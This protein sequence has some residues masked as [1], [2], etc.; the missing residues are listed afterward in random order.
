MTQPEALICIERRIAA[1]KALATYQVSV[2]FL[3]FCVVVNPSFNWRCSSLLSCIREVGN[4]QVSES[5][6]AVPC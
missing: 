2:R 5:G 1:T 4:Q 3:T 6:V